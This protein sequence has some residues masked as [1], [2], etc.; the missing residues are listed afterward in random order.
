MTRS[1]KEIALE[2]LEK[3]KD[4]TLVAR[5]FSPMGRPHLLDLAE[6]VIEYEKEIE[7][8]SKSTPL[9]GCVH[10]IEDCDLCV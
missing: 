4:Q 10:G 5:G 8:A 9:N 1:L 6:D 7:E 2:L 3:Y